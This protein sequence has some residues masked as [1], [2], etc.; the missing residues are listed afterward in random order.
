[1][2]FR[3]VKSQTQKLCNAYV[4]ITDKACAPPAY[5]VVGWVR[6][7]KKPQLCEHCSEI[8]KLLLYYQHC[9]QHRSN[10]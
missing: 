9:F 3:V 4:N 2:S 6:R 5:S 7:R 10:T 1:M 8:A